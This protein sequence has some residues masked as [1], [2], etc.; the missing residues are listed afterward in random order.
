MKTNIII[1][2]TSLDY[3]LDLEQVSKQLCNAMYE[4]EHLPALI[5]KIG[6]PEATILLFASGKMVING[7][8]VADIK[9]AKE[10]MSNLVAKL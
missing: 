1:R 2:A 7:K 5:Y 8:S 4:P 9:R 3:T 10:T 6:N